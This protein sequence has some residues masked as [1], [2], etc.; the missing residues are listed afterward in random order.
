MT[1]EVDHLVVGGGIIGI[2]IAD[3]LAR[4]GAS[5][6]VA[7]Q[8]S[9][10]RGCSEGNAGWITPSFA[11]PLPRPGLF[12]KAMRWMADPDSPFYIQPRPTPA[13][14]SW[15]MKFGL[16]MD[17]RGFHL[18]TAA[19]VDLSRYSL[20]A[21]LEIERNL[22]GRMGLEKEGLLMVA[23]TPRGFASATADAELMAGFGVNGVRLDAH[24]A[25]A[26]QPAL[27]EGLSG[28][29]YYPDEAH[30]LPMAALQVIADRARRAGVM[31]AE[32]TE[33][34]D[35]DVKD[36]RIREVLTT[37]GRFKAGKVVLATGA[38]SRNLAR[39]LG[40]SL[41]VMGG[42]GYSMT[43]QAPTSSSR[44]P[45]MI[46][47]RKVAVTP[48]GDRLR[49]AGTL[50][51]VA[52]DYSIS[53]RRVESIRKSA[54]TALRLPDSVSVDRIWRGL[55]PCTPDGLPIIGRT[56]TLENLFLATGH[57][58]LGI[59]TAPATARLTTDLILGNDPIFD[60]VPFRPERF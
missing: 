43:V 57:Q 41:P 49:L 47:E 22:P 16:A 51:L 5:V 35:F 31:I 42:K 48:V 3:A 56:S 15:L 27:R 53:P 60:P 4:E 32:R 50:E 52:D 45:A 18:G 33:V 54:E 23:M 30:I 9:I 44:V 7:D 36:G 58:M 59:Q 20:D 28:A 10:G 24:E 55:R 29:I 13:T 40:L 19:L 2:M 17:R 37:R 11:M 12:W 25:I 1:R 21:Y 8:G 38:W 14:I 39:R 26:V 46:M 6:V 34:F